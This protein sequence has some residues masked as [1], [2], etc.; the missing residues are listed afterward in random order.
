ML[1][2][3][4]LEVLGDLALTF[5]QAYGTDILEKRCRVPGRL[6]RRVRIRKGRFMFLART[7]LP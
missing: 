2:R 7:G 6:I 1:Y 4:R 3:L 5:A